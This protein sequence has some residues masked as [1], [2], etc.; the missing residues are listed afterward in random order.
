MS[1]RLQAFRV[2]NFKA[3]ANTQCIP[4]K[5]ITLIFG[6]NSAGKSSF[7]HSMALAHEA[8]FGREKRG[9]SRLDVH[10][11]DIGGTAID[12]GGF[13]QYVHRGEASRRVEWGA[14]I[15]VSDMQGRIADLLSSV[16][17][18]SISTWIGI[19]RDDRDRPKAGSSPRVESV[20]ISCDGQELISMSR[21]PNDEAGA[22]ILRIDRIKMD[23]TVFR[24]FV[25][26]LIESATTSS[27]VRA[28]D[29]ITAS[30]V[31]GTLITRLVVRIDRFLPASIEIPEADVL[32]GT[33]VQLFPLSKGNRSEDLAEAIKLYLP[34][35]LNDVIKG[36]SAALSDELSRFQYLGPLRSFPARHLAFSEHEDANWY[37]GGG[38]AWDMIRRDRE[39][40]EK[41]NAWLGAEHLKTRYQLLIR[42]LVEL[43]SLVD[44]V[45]RALS[46]EVFEMTPEIFSNL[47]EDA[48]KAI[49]ALTWEGQ[50]QSERAEKRLRQF[51]ES[52]S[53]RL[54]QITDVRDRSILIAQ[55]IGEWNSASLG[56]RRRS[57][58]EELDEEAEEIDYEQQA[59]EIVGT[60]EISGKPPLSELVLR[61]LRNGTNVTH[62]DVGIGISQVLPVLVLAYGSKQKLIAM[63]QPEIHLHPALQAELADVFVESALGSNGNTF[64]LETHS[65]HLILRLMRRIREGRLKPSDVCVL[66]VEPTDNGSRAVEL[67]I[68]EEG[69]FIDEWPGGFFE[70]SF[71]EKFAGR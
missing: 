52:W 43:E 49:Y 29:Y 16:K 30:E 56:S 40:R 13:R 57:N 15:D 58:G 7:I 1:R 51:V 54:R 34:R 31:V 50:L 12:L 48:D 19:E 14:Q 8:Q 32:S 36:I 37:A 5:P 53:L 33:T 71:H 46:G 69:D 41:V 35:T 17:V 44:P 64:I 60:I 18:L 66:F 24:T 55:A 2:G 11:T 26:A 28:E 25:R 3:F 10:H 59:K 27:E 38:Y 63:E 9:L 68:D 67:R 6:P 61:D 22:E 47:I 65:E 4:L 70:E 23:H 62:R 39:V 42:R 45:A 21:R 20:A